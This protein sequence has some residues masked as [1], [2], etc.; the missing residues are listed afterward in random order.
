MRQK[1]LM[2]WSSGKDSAFA[3]HQLMNDDSYEVAGL[4]T[5][6]TRDYDR[7]SMH[8]VR[9]AL[10]EAQAEN[11]GLPL[12]IVWM[13]AGGS[14]EDYETQMRVILE[15]QKDQGVTAIAIGDI[16]LEDLRRYREEKLALVGMEAV[17][18]IWGRDTRELSREFVDS[19]FQS[20][21]TCVDSESMPGSFAGRAY[22]HALLAELPSSVDPC[23][24]NGEFHS[25]AFGG[26]I[27]H[28]PINFDKGEIV[29]RDN[30]FYFCDLIPPD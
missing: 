25:F 2:S 15:E 11:I 26:P 8:G 13:S 6:L 1:V 9:R 19:G 28:S 21:I 7:V 12:H 29:L 10:L 30:R 16:F 14:N 18:P 4:L 5:T 17:F 27:F 3:L 20:I 22:D 24:E 23:G